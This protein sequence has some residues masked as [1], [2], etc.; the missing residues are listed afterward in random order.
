MSTE[1]VTLV[2]NKVW[3]RFSDCSLQGHWFSWWV[4]SG[5]PRWKH[6][7]SLGAQSS[8][9][10]NLLS[11]LCILA[12]QY[13]SRAFGTLIRKAKPWKRET[14][15]VL[16]I[17]HLCGGFILCGPLNHMVP[18]LIASADPIIWWAAFET[19]N[20]IFPP[21]LT[22]FSLYLN[23]ERLSLLQTSLQPYPLCFHH[24]LWEGE[25]MIS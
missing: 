15:N 2:N 16:I 3:T 14:C 24:L 6:M 19:F 20:L 25:S 7:A 10:W 9:F 12:P 17:S 23:S 4:I 13:R 1:S 11:K 18:S 8:E 5:H 21:L 22:L